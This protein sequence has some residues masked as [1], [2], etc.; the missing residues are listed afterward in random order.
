MEPEISP[1]LKRKIIWTKPSPVCVPCEF[2]WCK[3]LI[4]ASLHLEYLPV[5]ALRTCQP[6]N[7]Q[8]TAQAHWKSTNLH[9]FGVFFV[10]VFEIEKH[11]ISFIIHISNKI[12]SFSY[13]TI[14]ECIQLS[15]L[16]T[17]IY[18]SVI[19]MYRG[20]FAYSLWYCLTLLDLVEWCLKQVNFG[21]RPMIDTSH[22]RFSFFTISFFGM[23]V[24]VSI[25]FW[26][27]IFCFSNQI[28]RIKFGQRGCP[29]MDCKMLYMAS[30]PTNH[31]G[32]QIIASRRLLHIPGVDRVISEASTVWHMTKVQ[33][34]GTKRTFFNSKPNCLF[35]DMQH[36][37]VVWYSVDIFSESMRLLQTNRCLPNHNLFTLPK[38]LILFLKPRALPNI[39]PTKY[40]YVYTYI[41]H[42]I[43]RKFHQLSHGLSVYLVTSVKPRHQRWIRQF[44]HIALGRRLDHSAPAKNGCF[45]GR[46]KGLSEPK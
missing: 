3:L 23:F 32:R 4:Q 43:P 33:P 36:H 20:N 45:Y 18:V 40:T 7:I 14:L 6:Q 12:C 34:L 29:H 31:L 15:L 25:S 41:F 2:P 11:L 13:W 35:Q 24:Q 8:Q 44:L 9:F 46:W 42:S 27:P 30:H 16:N 21:E 17:F 19:L 10:W 26:E 38:S 5:S 1:G 39:F 28:D 37:S 22:M